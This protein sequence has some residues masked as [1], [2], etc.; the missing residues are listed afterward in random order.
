[1]ISPGLARLT[2]V[3][4][5]TEKRRLFQQAEIAKREAPRLH[6]RRA[7]TNIEL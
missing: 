2:F 6:C 5:Y 1:M 4:I 7:S 3:S